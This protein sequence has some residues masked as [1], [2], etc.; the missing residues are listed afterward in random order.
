[1]AVLGNEMTNAGYAGTSKL[2]HPMYL[3]S[4]ES[5]TPPRLPDEV[6]KEVGWN[7]LHDNYAYDGINFYRENTY[8]AFMLNTRIHDNFIVNQTGRG[9]LIGSY[10]VGP[11]IYIY[12]NVIISAG[13]GPDS[14]YTSDPAFNYQCVYFN[15]GWSAYPG[16]TTIHFYNNTLYDC[17]WNDPGNASS[18]SSMIAYDNSNPFT[19]DFRNNIIQATSWPYFSSNGTP[20][21]GSGAKNVWYGQGTAPSWDSSPVTQN[22]M[23]VSPA[24]PTA[25][26]HLQSGSPAIGAGTAAA[27]SVAVDFDNLLRPSPPSIGAFEFSGAS[28]PPADSTAPSVPTGLS[29]TAASS[30]QVNLSWNASTDPDNSASQIAYSVYRNGTQLGNTAAGSTTYSD[31]GLTAGTTYAYT[32]AAFDPAGNTSTQSSQVLV[33]TPSNPVPVISSFTASPSSITAGGSSTLS[34]S[35][36]AATSLSVSG[37]GTVSGTSVSVSPAQTTT[38]TLTATNSAGSATA[39]TIVTVTAAPV[40]SVQ[41]SPATITL[42][43]G[44]QQPFT[45]TV[46]G[47]TNTAVTWSFTPSVGT[48]SSAGLYTAPASITSAQTATIKATSV[49]DATK[50]ATATVTLQPPASPPPPTSPPPTPA[51]SITVTPPSVTLGPGQQ[52]P[53][54]ANVIGATNTAVTWSFTPAIWRAFCGGT[55]CS[56]GHAF[57][58]AEHYR[59]SHFGS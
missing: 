41:I 24:P 25:N 30:S 53:F 6:N 10:V 26:V 50:S 1:V 52:Q 7:Y 54:I 31:G 19:L 2:Y 37:I 44:Q 56:A 36:T 45:A 13:K 29:A 16:T 9:M 34:W 58:H 20:S 21:S 59:Q 48:L 15:A 42:S 18:D 43:Q 27:P 49:A 35:V 47:A 22:P 28:A 55:L 14:K 12:N 32:V 33:T 3:Q 23:L 5:G 57:R 46:T 17:G 8:S 51:V 38:Y 39:Q 40:I 11:D 4:G